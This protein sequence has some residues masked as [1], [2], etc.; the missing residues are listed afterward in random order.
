VV[1]VAC[2]QREQAKLENQIGAIK[3]L[4]NSEKDPNVG[5]L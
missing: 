1:E 5:I 2:R 4:N 3:K